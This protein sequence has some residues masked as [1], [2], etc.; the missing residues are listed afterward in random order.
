MN[1]VLK[2]LHP[3]YQHEDREGGKVIVRLQHKFKNGKVKNSF[4]D[5]N[6]LANFNKVHTYISIADFYP[7]FD[8][9]GKPLFSE[10]NTKSVNFLVIDMDWNRGKV[11]QWGDDTA[12]LI[13][14]TLNAFDFWEYVPRPSLIL[15]SGRG[16]HFIYKFDRLV[17]AKEENKRQ[18]Q[19][20]LYVD[21]CNA[22]KEKLQ[23]EYEELAN[24][25]LEEYGNDLLINLKFDKQV[26]GYL[27]Q[28]FRLPESYHPSVKKQG[29]VIQPL[30]DYGYTLGEL[31]KDCKVKKI[32]NTPLKLYEKNKGL[33]VKDL[34]RNRILDIIR[35]AEH[36]KEQNGTLEGCRDILLYWASWCLVNGGLDESE[37]DPLCT[38]LG[39]EFADKKIREEKIRSAK[40]QHKKGR[41]KY[42]NINLMD[43]LKISTE[44]EQIME[45]L[46]TR[47]NE[48]LRVRAEK[49]RKKE[50]KIEEIRKVYL[51][52]NL[53]GTL[54]AEI[55]G[56]SRTTV[57]KY[58][59]DLKEEYKLE[60]AKRLLEEAEA[61]KAREKLIPQQMEGQ[62]SVSDLVKE[63]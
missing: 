25:L 38:L 30:Q 10:N 52:N 16:L 26:G 41:N 11:K 18:H 57:V 37:I 59:R 23:I 20:S 31:V 56:I 42:K 49:R 6:E 40:N 29:T 14:E 34:N 24:S 62:I 19:I 51:E 13:V 32:K 28:I 8:K 58:T 60:E 3:L 61:E 54:T 2:L 46:T 9:D 48:A 4:V 45:T 5:I 44:E 63:A 17:F 47:N 33:N 43:R 12:N 39:A 21:T 15:N 55:M 53:N 7:K 1:D 27:N 36:R 50:Q 35:L 22:V